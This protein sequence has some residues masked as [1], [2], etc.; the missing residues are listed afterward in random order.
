MLSFLLL[1]ILPFKIDS[2][3]SFAIKPPDADTAVDYQASVV[4][5]TLLL[6]LKAYL[7]FSLSRDSATVPAADAS[8][9]FG[10]SSAQL[11]VPASIAMSLLMLVNSVVGALTSRSL[12]ARSTH[13]ISVAVTAARARLSVQI[14]RTGVTARTRAGSAASTAGD[15]IARKVATRRREQAWA[16]ASTVSERSS[17]SDAS[18]TAARAPY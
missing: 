15:V 4:M 5:T 18:E 3:A 7:F 6:G 2:A 13:H 11:L 12:A 14:P 8:S 1:A 10:A 9:S 17:E 16:L